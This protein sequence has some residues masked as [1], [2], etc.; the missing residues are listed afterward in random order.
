MITAAEA[1]TYAAQS[2]DLPS[3]E[4]FWVD[5]QAFV[6]HFVE[7]EWAD[8]D[9]YRFYSSSRQVSGWVETSDN[10]YGGLDLSWAVAIACPYLPELHRTRHFRGHNVTQE[11]AEA[12]YIRLVEERREC[13]ADNEEEGAGNDF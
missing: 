4:R 5:A 7:Q 3:L 2:N 10:A 1:E 11:E 6:S 13:D 9:D 12:A 8:M